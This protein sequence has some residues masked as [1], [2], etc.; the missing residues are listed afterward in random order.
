[1]PN[2]KV[3]VSTEDLDTNAYTQGSSATLIPEPGVIPKDRQAL[4]WRENY[5]LSYD[6]IVG[7]GVTYRYSNDP[8]LRTE[9]PLGVALDDRPP[10]GTKW[11][12]VQILAPIIPGTLQ[13]T[14]TDIDGG[15]IA[16]RDVPS[17]DPKS[18]TGHLV[19]S[20]NSSPPA[21]LLKDGVKAVPQNIVDYTT[22]SF[23]FA[24]EKPVQNAT[25]LTVSYKYTGLRLE[26]C[27]DTGEA[28]IIYEEGRCALRVSSRSSVNIPDAPVAGQEEAAT[29]ATLWWTAVG[30]RKVESCTGALVSQAYLPLPTPTIIS[31]AVGPYSTLIE[32]CEKGPTQTPPANAEFATVFNSMPQPFLLQGFG[33]SSWNTQAYEQTPL[34]SLPMLELRKNSASDVNGNL[35]LD[36]YHNC[37]EAIASYRYTLGLPSGGSII[38]ATD[39]Q[40]K[41]VTTQSSGTMHQVIATG[42]SD[43]PPGINSLLG[44]VTLNNA[45]WA[46][47]HDYALLSFPDDWADD[48]LNPKIPNSILKGV[49]VDDPQGFRAY[50]GVESKELP[51]FPGSLPV[52]S[53]YYVYDLCEE[54]EFRLNDRTTDDLPEGTTNVYHS[55]ERVTTVIENVT[56]SGTGTRVTTTGT[57]SGGDF[58]TSVDIEL[59]DIFSGDGILTR[60]SSGNYGTSDDVRV[61]ANGDVEVP[62]DL[63]VGGSISVSGG[64]T[65]TETDPVFTAHAASGVT[66]TRLTNWDSAHTHAG[67]AHAPSDATA[68]DTDSNLRDRTTH[69]GTQ[70]ASTISDFDVEVGNH[71]DVAANTAHSGSTHAPTNADNT[72]AN[73]TSHADVVVD[74]DFSSAGIMV[75]GAQAGNYTVTADN[76]ANWDSAYTHSQSAHAPS[77]ATANDSDSNLRD[78]STHTGTQTAST[79]SDFD[80]EVGNHTDVAANTSHRGSAH[81]PA[82]ATANDSDA[83]LKNRANHTGTQPA[84]TISDFDTEVSNNTDVAANIAH[85]ASAHAPSNATANS[86]DATL[87]DRANH[88]GTQTASTISDFDTEVS[89]NQTVA[90]NSAHRGTAHA[91]SDA[92]NTAANETSHADVVVDGDFSA[93][94][95]MKRGA[96]A[97]TYSTITDNSSNWDDAYTH[98]QAA[99]APSNAEA[100]V[101]SDW[102]ASSGDAEILNKPKMHLSY[103]GFMSVQALAGGGIGQGTNITKGASGSGALTQQDT[104]AYTGDDGNLRN[105]VIDIDRGLAIAMFEANTNGIQIDTVKFSVLESSPA[106]RGLT[107]GY[108]LILWKFSPSSGTLA[109][110]TVTATNIQDNSNSGS[111]NLGMANG[112]SP[113]QNS[114]YQ[115]VTGTFGSSSTATL[116]A[117]ERLFFSVAMANQTANQ[118]DSFTFTVDIDLIT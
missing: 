39:S 75:R 107:D 93:T 68:N 37:K 30:T 71:P 18:N 15:A 2:W 62:G 31:R 5:P 103:T 50:D 46:D 11:V 61:D 114:G 26:D 85:A 113:P 81:A 48:L 106:A 58:R 77:N 16:I 51:T 56:E 53:F 38:S 40:G 95:L 4:V 59:D 28:D 108:A 22:G 9:V 101:K 23:I 118:H 76:S 109:G 57:H 97:G 44:T 36:V 3:R 43:H 90:A 116:S 73:E 19:G 91:P 8:S 52:N 64:V 49:T 6:I 84:S 66:S 89:N 47:Y 35:V 1:M 34:L 82:N 12:G 112:Q 13:V 79:I 72:A 60:D 63:T 41:T 74:G 115:E 117:G 104:F 67:T 24:L 7:D 20:V 100:N 14:G 92:D 27:C 25:S 69:T 110:A 94:G 21:I 33:P 83:N 29:T 99:H 70:A 32:A 10:A 80:T 55:D 111:I 86:S 102:S 42:G 65:F 17:G 45:S 105:S 87:K 88:T 78:R 54:R 98:S 96:S